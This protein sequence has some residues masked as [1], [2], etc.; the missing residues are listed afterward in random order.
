[1]ETR[2]IPASREYEPEIISQGFFP[3][4]SFVFDVV[5]ISTGSSLLVDNFFGFDVIKV[6]YFFEVIIGE[7]LS[8]IVGLVLIPNI[9]VVAEVGETV[10][11]VVGVIFDSIQE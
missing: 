10:L 7:G 4:D 6:V 8:E 5:I 1:M 11:T 2:E 3:G 9:A